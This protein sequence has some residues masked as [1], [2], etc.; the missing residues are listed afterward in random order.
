MSESNIWFREPILCNNIPR[1]V[2][3]WTMPIVI[4]R[5]AHGD[6]YRAKDFVVQ[7]AGKFE[8]L[9]TPK[10][11]GDAGAAQRIQVF[12]FPAGGCAMGMYNTDE[13]SIQHRRSLQ[14]LAFT[15]YRFLKII[16]CLLGFGWFRNQNG[17]LVSSGIIFCLNKTFF[18]HFDCD[19]V[20][21]NCRFCGSKHE[22]VDFLIKNA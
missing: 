12:D 2:P 10:D 21:I 8:L 15:H 14:L 11:G 13:V 1:L 9:F 3:G 22:A 5:H 17:R 19:Y 4:G 6:Q 16:F 18:T 20:R 7:T